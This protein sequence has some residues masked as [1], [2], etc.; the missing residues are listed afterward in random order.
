MFCPRCS[1]PQPT[2]GTRF[3]PRCGFRLDEVKELF[4]HEQARPRDETRAAGGLPP[5]R[6]I[7]LGALLMF[8]GTAAALLWGFLMPHMPPDRVLPQT[9]FILGVTLVFILTL[10]HPL[11]GALQRLFSDGDAAPTHPRRRDGINLGALLMFLVALKVMLIASLGRPGAANRALLALVFSAN[12]LLLLFVL[13]PVL[14]AVHRLLFKAD[15]RADSPGENATASLDPAKGGPALPPARAIPVNDFAPVRAD[16]ADM[17]APP[18]VAE[19][20]TRKLSDL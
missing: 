1:Q 18:S 2:D 5:Q 10:F 20:T 9:Y 12:A 8:A 14:R 17:V 19:G 15:A 11:L 13:R 7:S 6:H 3:C 16:T 4:E